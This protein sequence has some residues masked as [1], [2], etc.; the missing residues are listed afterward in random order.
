[1][2]TGSG[3]IL[4]SQ[5][6]WGT[7]WDVATCQRIGSPLP[8]NR[9]VSAAAF[10]VSDSRILTAD[11]DGAIKVWKI[12]VQ[13]EPLRTFPHPGSVECVAFNS[14]GN[15]AATGGRDNA[16]NLWDVERG[17]PL[18]EPL[19]HQGPVSAAVF[20]P[21]RSELITASMDGSVEFWDSTAGQRL[22]LRVRHP[23]GEWITTLAISS[24]GRLLL[25]GSTD[26]TARLWSLPD[27]VSRELQLQEGVLAAAFEHNNKQVL[28]GGAN[29][30]I[31]VWDVESP[32]VR[33]PGPSSTKAVRAIVIGPDKK[34]VWTAG[35]DRRAVRW[36]NAT[37]KELGKPVF[38]QS[39]IWALALDSTG[40]I[41]FTGSEDACSQ[42]WDAA[43]GAPLGPPLNGLRR[44]K[45]A[46]FRPGSRQLLTGSSDGAM[47]W[48]S[49]EPLKGDLAQV[50][51]IVELVTGFA[52]K[53]NGVREC[54]T[55]NEWL[56]LK[57]TCEQAARENDH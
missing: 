6:G 28:A 9:L 33:I 46:V 10:S 11:F 47:L 51:L 5:R 31:T 21:T 4:Q 57:R 41:L 24:D 44:V 52:L 27:L 3:E 13:P 43:T 20:H 53:G 45:A 40:T 55:G 19:T 42:F 36:D 1:M 30:S 17:L 18:C 12:S 50:R 32:N 48:D 34:S 56:K 8:H 15:V 2:F 38:S 23:S 16:V 37:Y 26:T 22:N 54:L 49:P 7:L 29:G 39:R 25:T 14:A 35:D